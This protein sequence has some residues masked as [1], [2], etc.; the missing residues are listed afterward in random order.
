MWNSRRSILLSKI[1]VVIFMGALLYV[2]IRAPRLVAWLM[3]MTRAVLVGKSWPFLATI[4]AG[5]IPAAALLVCLY[6]LLHRIAQG[7]VF[8]QK[9]VAS[10]RIISW[11]CIVGAV[12]CAVS[13]FYYFPWFIVAIAAAFVGLIVR[14][15]KNV[16]DRAVALQI[17][18]DFTI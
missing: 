11:C 16:F 14:V 7:D 15:V 6:M 4:Y 13:A 1:C 10:L 12:I 2:A 9:N 5:C 3:D 8:V 17:E 18:A